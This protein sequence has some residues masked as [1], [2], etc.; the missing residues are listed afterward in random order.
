MPARSWA[1]PSHV[2]LVSAFAAGIGIPHDHGAPYGIYVNNVSTFTGDISNAARSA[3][4]TASSSAAMRDHTAWCQTRSLRAASAIADGIGGL[5]RHLRQ[6]C[7]ELRRHRQCRHD[8]GGSGRHQRHQYRHVWLV[9]RWR[10]HQQFRHDL[11]RAD[12]NLCQQRCDVL[13]QCQQCQ[14]DHGRCGC[15]RIDSGVTFGPSSAIVN[16]GIITGTGGTAIDASAAPSAV[17][18]DQTAGAVNGAI[19]PRPMP[20]CRTFQAAR[21]P[22]ISSAR[23]PEYDQFQSGRHLT[24]GSAYG[25][26]GVPGQ[27]NSG[28]G[29]QRNQQRHLYR[30]Q[31]RRD[32]CRRRHA[33]LGNVNIGGTLAPGTPGVAGTIMNINGNLAFQSG[34]I[35]LVTI[36]GASV[37]RVDVTGAVSLNGALDVALQPGNFR[38]NAPYDIL[39]P[40]SIS[41]RFSSVNIVDLPPGLSA[42]VTYDTTAVYLDL[43]ASLGTGDRLNVNQ[44][45]VANAINGYFN[46]G[47]SL[48]AASPRS[49]RPSNSATRC[50]L[51]EPAT[52][53]SKGADQLMN[54]FLNLMLDPTAGGEAGRMAAARQ[55]LRRAGCKPAP[56]SRSLTLRR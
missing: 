22:A 24:Y 28:E 39:D 5:D 52:D 42:I 44:Q 8:L 13:R 7:F 17:T 21:S 10:R 50:R 29:V 30:C 54:D 49:L 51:G 40:T 37:S 23:A 1:A 43:M 45:N 56:M 12:R 32:A 2:Q 6:Q 19:K 18:I 11:G 20:T 26:T 9:E 15:I 47:G 25:F 41:G 14:H 53:A 55:A 46:A 4:I 31:Q 36:A 38:S 33:E 48:P 16:S 3:G 27:R 35:Y 34:A